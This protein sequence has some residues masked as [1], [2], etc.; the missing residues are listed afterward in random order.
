MINPVHDNPPD[1]VNW[2]K[3]DWPGDNRKE[4]PYTVK[5]KDYDI[6]VKILQGN[7]YGTYTLSTS[8]MFVNVEVTRKDNL[9][10]SLPVHL[11][12]TGGDQTVDQNITLDAG[13]NYV[14]ETY[15]I[16]AY[17]SGSYTIQ[18]QAWPSGNSWEDIYPPDN[19]DSMT[20]QYNYTPTPSLLDNG[21]HG[22]LIN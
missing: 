16:T 7:P 13:E 19:T 18:A 3:G 11:T 15:N 10:G 17:Q 22:E 12:I 20:L 5:G 2:L 9:P 8:D 1:E 4:V 14:F 6:K 21:L